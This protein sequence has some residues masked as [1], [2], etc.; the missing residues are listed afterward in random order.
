MSRE[1]TPWIR[2]KEQGMYTLDQAEWAVNVHPR[3]GGMSSKCTPWARVHGTNWNVTS[4]C[5]RGNWIPTPIYCSCSNA[6]TYRCTQTL[7]HEWI[8]HNT[9]VNVQ[10]YTQSKWESVT[11]HQ[12][13]NTE[14]THTHTRVH[15]LHTW[16]TCGGWG[17]DKRAKR[18]VISAALLSQQ[19]GIRRMGHPVTY[20]CLWTCHPRPL[21]LPWWQAWGTFG[22][23]D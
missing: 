12:W 11:T 19:S 22:W 6:N 5:I 3:S 23:G 8:Q 18:L 15:Q 20:P 10:S 13:M 4:K 14:H 7:I 16:H 17:G 9:L 21:Q 1:C 2:W